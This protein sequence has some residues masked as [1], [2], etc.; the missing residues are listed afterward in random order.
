MAV[1]ELG[2]EVVVA[3]NP[4]FPIHAV[5]QRIDWAGLGDI[6]FKHVTSYEHCH[7]CKPNPDYYREIVDRIGR[8]PQECL[9]VGNDVEEDLAAAKIGMK[10]YLVTDCLLNSK[11]L[12]F[13]TDYQGTLQELADSIAGIIKAENGGVS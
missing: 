8:Q 1:L 7:F 2:L 12:D 5:R 6:N 11:K 10:T 4:I 13:T 9:M 3:T